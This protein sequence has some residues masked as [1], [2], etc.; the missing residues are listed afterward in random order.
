[1]TPCTV[2]DAR[3]G[4][5]VRPAG[6]TDPQAIQRWL[7]RERS[8]MLELLERLVRAESQPGEPASRRASFALLAA[9]L[10]RAGLDVRAV[11]GHGIGDH[12]YARPRRRRRGAPRQLVLGHFDSAGP[13]GPARRENGLLYGPG[14]TAAKGALVV[15]AFALRALAALGLE[16]SVTPVVVVNTDAE[17]GSP[18]SS[19][20]IRLLARG[21]ARALVLGPDATGAG[22]LTIGRSSVG[23]FTVRVRGEGTVR[24]GDVGDRPSRH[25][26]LLALNDPVAGVFVDVAG[27]GE[28]GEGQETSVDVDV[29]ATTVAG[30][31]RVEAAIRALVSSTP[32]GVVEIHGGFLRPPMEPLARNRLLFGAAVRLGHELGVSLADAGPAAGVGSDANTTS[33]YTATLDG[34]GPVGGA[35]GTADEYVVLAS[36]PERAALL[37]LLLL[38]PP[39]M[40]EA[41]RRRPRRVTGRVAVVGSEA[42]TAT[43]D[44]VNACE[45][46]G[47]PAEL[48]GPAEVR[49]GDTVLGRLDVLPTLDG[50]EPGLLQL[51]LLERRGVRVINGAAMLAQAHDKLLTTRALARASLPHPATTHLRTGRPLPH[52]T[53]PVVV[54]PRFG[55]WGADVFRCDTWEEIEACLLAVCD[56]G[57]FRRHGALVQ[58]LVPP[59]GR[60][61]RLVV[62]GARVVGAVS[63]VAAPGEWRT[64]T[65]LGG[66]VAKLEPP[67]AACRLAIAAAASIGAG[68]VGVD[69]L[70]L[71]GGYTIVELNGAV[72]FDA[73]Y[74]LPGE[75]V[76]AATVAA[77]GLAPAG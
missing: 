36:L 56:R 28:Q 47:V 76:F 25:A 5:G 19:R 4:S 52:V 17:R 14:A 31:R 64:N 72:E 24:L 10:E 45:A 23:R 29:R 49:D 51:L 8:A 69:L 53:P 41:P 35:A 70:P 48:V 67:E 34:L 65:S 40:L 26:R 75:D 16:P 44:L 71:D 43:V 6:A 32:E 39:P 66:S 18:D 77:L 20:L 21:A 59:A 33:L 63:R 7:E 58:E 62:A 30:A 68:L 15:L 37:A 42:N 55:S 50:I 73:G 11:R 13:P 1:M 22:G 27:A 57:W 38:E 60:D 9:E 61:L 54:K 46:R 3:S 2:T 74:S 12:L